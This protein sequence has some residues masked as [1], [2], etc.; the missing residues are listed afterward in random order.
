[1]SMPKSKVLR[2][3]G[4][5]VVTACLIGGL[6][7]CFFSGKTNLANSDPSKQE[8]EIKK[9]FQDLISKDQKL[10]GLM[11]AHGGAGRYAGLV[12][13]GWALSNGLLYET[14]HGRAFRYR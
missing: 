7:A 9:A 13:F 10:A 11:E 4:W 12:R 8:P 3:L 2:V 14:F 5:C 1:M 6:S